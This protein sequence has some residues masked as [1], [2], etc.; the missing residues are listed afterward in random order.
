MPILLDIR[1]KKSGSYLFAYLQSTSFLKQEACEIFGV[2]NTA[3]WNKIF[4]ETFLGNYA[5]LLS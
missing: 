1:Y 4:F 3:T 2:L 5:A